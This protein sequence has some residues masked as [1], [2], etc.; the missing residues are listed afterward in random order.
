MRRGKPHEDRGHRQRHG[1][2]ALSRAGRGRSDDFDITTFC[3]EPRP[4][5]DRVQ[6][7]SFFSGKSAADLSIG[8]KEFFEKAR[9]TLRLNDAVLSIDPV[10]KV[11]RSARY[12]EVAYDKLILAT[13]SY[14]FVPKVAGHDRRDCFVYRTIEDLEAITATRGALEGRRRH[15]RRPARPRGC[16]GAEGPRA[17]D[18][19]RRVRLAPD[20]G[21]AR[22]FGRPPAA[23]E[24]R[25]LLGL[26]VHLQK[27]T[28]EITE[29]T[30][31]RQRLVFA[32]GTS[33]ETDIIV[34]SAG[35]R[36]RDELARAAGLVVGERGGVRIDSHCRT[37][38][39]D[40]YA[41]GECALWEGRIFGLVAPGY[42][43][44]EVAARHI[45]GEEQRAVPRRRPQHQAEA[46]GVDVAS[47]GDAHAERRTR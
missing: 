35:I 30:V 33:L 11:L 41:I 46:D 6:L 20:G 14:P 40:I 34:F 1:R 29:G 23:Q 4:A 25:K 19:Y 7:T 16:Q 2:P 27:S 13:G 18:A 44:A 36:P 5:Y 38:N 31:R 3:E 12:R 8:K 17:R 24:D 32:D 21:A 26:P 22:R 37:S 42:Q 28:K 45:A 43:M 39:P 15:R 47:I 10:R 9:M